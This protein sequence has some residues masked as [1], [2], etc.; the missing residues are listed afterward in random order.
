MRTIPVTR[1]P[2]TRGPL[3]LS[4][5]LAVGKSS[6]SEMNTIMPEMRPNAIPYTSGPNASFSTSQPSSAP[7]CVCVGGWVWFCE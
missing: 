3:V 2:F 7:V 5:F 1:N 6:L 4:N